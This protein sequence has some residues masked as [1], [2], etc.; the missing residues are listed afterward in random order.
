MKFIQLIG[1]HAVGKSAIAGYIKEKYPNVLVLGEYKKS[2]TSEYYTGGMDNLDMT[3]T[4]RFTMIEDAW[5]SEKEVILCEGFIITQ[6]STFIEKYYALQFKKMRDVY[7]ILLTCDLQ[8]VLDRIN[9]RGKKE[10][11]QKRLE[12]V[13]N[14]ITQASSIFGKITETDNY[15]K[16]KFDTTDDDSFPEIINM[17]SRII[18]K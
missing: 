5:L 18:E 4:E 13:R 16:L 8:R 6:Y 15:K 12:N 10:L 1:G 14:K 17:I 9:V 7:I 3:N 2:H 11:S